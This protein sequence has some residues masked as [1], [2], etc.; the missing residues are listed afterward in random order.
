M[1]YRVMHIKEAVLAFLFQVY[2]NKSVSYYIQKYKHLK[3]GMPNSYV[4]QLVV[5]Q[6]ICYMCDVVGA[7]LKG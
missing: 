7:S 5:S 4:C 3:G 6:G 1:E 2:C